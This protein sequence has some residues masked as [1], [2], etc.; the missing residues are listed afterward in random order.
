MT[1]SFPE[2][3]YNPQALSG[4]FNPIEQVDLAPAIQAEQQ[5]QMTPE[6]AR[7]QELAANDS[8]RIK[9]AGQYGRD[10]QALGK[11]SE[12]LSDQLLEYQK[13]ENEK[14][15]QR[16]MMN[17]YTEGVSP[18][19]EK[20][21]D[22]KEALLEQT[23]VAAEK[24]AA[25]AEANGASVFTGEKIRKMSGWEKYGYV[26]GRMQIHSQGFPLFIAQNSDREFTVNGE[27]F[28]LNS[29]KT[30]E[31][32]AAA[33]QGLLAEY[34][35]P[36]KEY[37]TAM[38]SKYLLKPL[39]GVMQQQMVLFAQQRGKE[40][41][42]ERK[43]ERANQFVVGFKDLEPGANVAEWLEQRVNE[44]P[45]G[46]R[47][48]RLEYW[49]VLTTAIDNETISLEDAGR[50][51]LDFTNFGGGKRESWVTKFPNDFGSLS[52]LI[53]EKRISINSRDNQLEAVEKD[54]FLDALE[55]EVQ[56][57]AT[58][59]KKK[60]LIR[61]WK[62][63]PTFGSQPVPD[64]LSGLYTVEQGILD[65]QAAYLTA[66]SKAN[67]GVIAPIHLVGKDPTV[68][69]EFA[70]QVG[71]GAAVASVTEKQG[72]FIK[73][74]LEGANKE[75]GLFTVGTTSFA[76]RASAVRAANVEKKFTELL[77]NNIIRFGPEEGLNQTIQ[78]MDDIVKKVLDS[79]GT[80]DPFSEVKGPDEVA[81]WDRQ[82]AQNY[83]SGKDLGTIAS[84]TR[85]LGV[86]DADLV[87]AKEYLE[88]G[89]G[90][91]P[92]IFTYLAGRDS[93]IS[94]IELAGRQLEV[95]GFRGFKLPEQETRIT[96]SD[97]AS[98]RHKLRH[99]NTPSRTYRASI[100]DPELVSVLD[101]IA[102]K[103]SEAHGGYD[104]Y[105]EGG[106]SA[107]QPYGSANSA[108]NNMFGKPLSQMTIGELMALQA[109]PKGVPGIH[110]AGRYQFIAATL[111]Q[112]V[113][114]MGITKDMIFS[115]QL[116]DAMALHRLRWRLNLN[117]STTGL[118][119]EWTGLKRLPKAQLQQLLEDAQDVFE[120]PY[121]RPELLLKGL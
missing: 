118:I 113:R 12:T 117:N 40:I 15:M 49:D 39:Q 60:E 94:A 74:Y 114:E 27:A 58:E 69:A 88:T 104:A 96:Q 20:E 45:L 101:Y 71:A 30:P 42:L 59:E 107:D 109:K 106:W 68:I 34:I 33:L 73:D 64:R 77:G 56:G 18:A 50:F 31:Q 103:E 36:Y 19:D 54:E 110:A 90:E 119:N 8:V 76:D 23:K 100:E 21:F 57:G 22:E 91:L 29:A 115:P 4:G 38:A 9:N 82:K 83:V 75:L 98:V 78:D 41:R 11:F 70:D 7:L 62:S 28:T 108:E 99:K 16:G 37:S 79:K 97:N 24:D 10:L 92:Y 102:S 14:A 51:V 44:H 32:Q 111:K 67:N 112:V 84:Q 89:T 53:E 65:D 63:H 55:A 95:S 116:Q 48:G 120:D 26:K 6:R 72:D 35:D 13:K 2:Q 121:N 66:V 81:Y 52:R 61:R 5:R 46:R 47:A 105:N 1:S 80:Y 3:Q 25:D 93:R 86:S 87:S 43:A 85:I 17:A